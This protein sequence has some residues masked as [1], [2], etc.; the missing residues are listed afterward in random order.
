[1]RG[2]L[3]CPWCLS[4]PPH[5]EKCERTV[6]ARTSSGPVEFVAC[7]CECRSQGALW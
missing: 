5:H 2:P 7:P 1:M 3:P 4:T 6:L